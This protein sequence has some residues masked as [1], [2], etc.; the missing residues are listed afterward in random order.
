MLLRS[1]CFIDKE[2]QDN[3]LFESGFENFIKFYNDH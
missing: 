2:K 1:T 3:S